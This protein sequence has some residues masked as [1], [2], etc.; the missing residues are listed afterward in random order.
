[1]DSD[2]MRLPNILEHVGK[3]RS[4]KPNLLARILV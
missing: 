1:M 4:L 3:K 2:T